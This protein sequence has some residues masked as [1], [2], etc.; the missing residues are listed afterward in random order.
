MDKRAIG[1]FNLFLSGIVSRLKD[2]REYFKNI[3]V[4]LKSGTKPFLASLEFEGDE[5]YFSFQG[6]KKK[7][8]PDEIQ[9]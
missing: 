8:T 7:I 4:T 3:T 9:N 2:N 6:V 1:K 5:L